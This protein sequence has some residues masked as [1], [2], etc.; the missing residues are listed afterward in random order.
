MA[1]TIPDRCPHFAGIYLILD[2]QWAQVRSLPEICRHAAQSGVTLFQYRFKN[3]SLKRAFEQAQELSRIV[4]ECGSKFIVNDRC[5]LA[6]AVEADGVHLGQTDLPVEIA[7]QIMGP[8]K[9]IG[10]STHRPDEV[11][12]ARPGMVDYLGFGPVFPTPTKFNHERPVGIEGIRT[13]RSL[14]TLPIFAIGGIT[15]DSVDALFAAGASGVAVASA[16]LGASDVA[17]ALRRFIDAWSATD[18]PIR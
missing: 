17:I 13:A 7:R 8:Q 16:V 1:D 11:V 18:L 3:I 12:L 2:E 4:K 5:D 10:L 14:S 15:A 6:L 9:I